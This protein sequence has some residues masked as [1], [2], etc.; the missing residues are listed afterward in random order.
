[1]HTKE[2]LKTNVDSPYQFSIDYT[3]NTLFFSYSTHTKDERFQLAYLNL[4]NKEFNTVSAIKDG[5]ASA[6]DQDKGKVYLGAK[7]G[8]YNFNLKTKQAN[9]LAS[10]SQSIWQMF[11]K[12]GLY[13]STYP[14][15]EAYLFKD[16]VINRVEEL[17]DTRA[18]LI[19]LDENKN[20]YYSNSSGL[21]K[22]NKS[23][24]EILS[25]SDDVVNGMNSDANGKLYFTSPNGIFR[26]NDK[27]NTIDRLVT[28]E[29]VYAAAIEKD[30]NILCGTDEG[31]VRF[32]KNKCHL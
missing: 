24:K 13:Y 12:D 19:A 29:N 16:G 21:F 7:G 1:M 14:K 25:L 23:N 5:F 15:E 22:Y 27:L 30:G 18:M 6:V 10:T 3:T 9:L 26:I 2:V 8:V 20:I 17:K 4:D 32:K 31:I 11:Y 28:L